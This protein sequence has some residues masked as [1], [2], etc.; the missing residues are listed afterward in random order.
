MKE[1]AALYTCSIKILPVCL[2]ADLES[3][4]APRLIPSD[5]AGKTGP[6]KPAQA[7]CRRANIPATDN[8]N[9]P[10]AAHP[11]SRYASCSALKLDNS[12]KNPK[13]D[14]SC[15][16]VRICLGDITHQ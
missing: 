2:L 6:E 8:G 5:L 10:A 13:Q 11:A 15:I 4:A 9:R 12:G 7:H 3:A 16:C 14:P 1:G